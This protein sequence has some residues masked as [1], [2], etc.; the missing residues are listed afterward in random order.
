MDE[1]VHSMTRTKRLR[2][3]ATSRETTKR[4]KSY[5]GTDWEEYD[6]D[7]RVHGTGDAR[8]VL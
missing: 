8:D 2:I 4:V 5:H 3:E 6:V 7:L 1:E